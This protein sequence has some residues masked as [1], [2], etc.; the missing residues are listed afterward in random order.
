VI[1]ARAGK[2]GGHG[3][4]KGLTWGPPVKYI[5]IPS[6]EAGTRATLKIMKELVLSPW[7]H[8]NPE[9]VWLARNVVDDVSPGPQ[10]DYRAM[11]GKILEFMKK[12]VSYRLDPSGLE[13]VPTPW[14]TL[15]VSGREDC[16]TQGTLVL[17][18]ER[19][20]VKIEELVVGDWIWGLNDWSEVTNVWGD[21]G[22]LET[23]QFNLANGRS[24]RLTPCHDV[25]VAGLDGE[26]MK[27]RASTLR[28]GQAIFQPDAG[29]EKVAR[30]RAEGQ[31]VIE[32]VV[33]DYAPRACWDIE[34]SDHYVW[35][36]EADWTTFQCD[37]HA[38]AIAALAMALGLKAGFR[39]VRG[40]PSRPDQWSHVYA[41]IGVP[42][43]GGK[44]EWLTVDSTQEE[45]YLG[46]DPPEART[47]GMKTWVIDPSLERSS[48][49][50]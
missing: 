23:F 27:V 49:H 40:D 31:L 34:T 39:T 42:K 29:P 47:L 17:H 7:G 38:T 19:G 26:P 44:T 20:L 45:S 11:A 36:P 32:S 2:A 35:L 18:R 9:I 24:M 15:L 5:E 25:P 4:Y 28:P 33:R 10:K 48:W 37:G 8:R 50:S 6:G 12:N 3:P 22:V 14:Y 16:F 13:Y 46:W 1:D 43:K 21:K 30:H 41:V